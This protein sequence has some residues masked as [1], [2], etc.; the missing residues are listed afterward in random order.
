MHSRVGHQPEVLLGGGGIF[1]RWG[2]VKEQWGHILEWDSRSLVPSSF[3]L[4]SPPAMKWAAFFYHMPLQHDIWFCFRPKTIVTSDYGLKTLKLWN[5]MNIS[6]FEVACLRYFYH[7]NRNM[8]HTEP[9]HCF[10][11][12]CLILEWDVIILLNDTQVK[13]H[14]RESGEKVLPHK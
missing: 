8:T 7:V 11:Q 4:C 10:C 6:S 3:S 13:T 12:R 5:K 14:W 1:G 9:P 2:L